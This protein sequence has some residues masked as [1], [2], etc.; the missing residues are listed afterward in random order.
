MKKVIRIVF[1]YI[2]ATSLLYMFAVSYSNTYNRINNEKI[3]PAGIVI[4][5][6]EVTVSVLH[7]K[8][9]IDFGFAEPESRFYYVLYFLSPD[10]LRNAERILIEAVEIII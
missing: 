1:L 10:S 9:T 5:G 4:N 7:D 8:I 3:A 6:G 2:L